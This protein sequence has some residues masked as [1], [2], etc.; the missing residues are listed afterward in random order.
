MDVSLVL[1][2]PYIVCYSRKTE[3][4]IEFNDR[5]K[6]FQYWLLFHLPLA[7]KMNR[8]NKDI[9][10]N[11]PMQKNSRCNDTFPNGLIESKLL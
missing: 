3:L 7:K 2:Y 10:K 8:S 6:G 9:W 1:R 4:Q 5:T 11:F